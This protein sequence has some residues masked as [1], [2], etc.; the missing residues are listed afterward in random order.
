MS[1]AGYLTPGRYTLEFVRGDTVLRRFRVRQPDDT[2]WDLTG[3]TVLAQIRDAD[4]TL[5]A[6]LGTTP[7]TGITIS[8]DDNEWIN[9]EITKEISETIPATTGETE[10]YWDLEITDS[11]GSRQTVLAGPVRVLA[12]VTQS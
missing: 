3:A 9:L 4:G 2:Y 11:L 5:L 1:L 7:G 12:E 10:H 8:G 6:D